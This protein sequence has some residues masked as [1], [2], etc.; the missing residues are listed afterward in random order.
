[1]KR[2]RSF[3][4]FFAFLC[5]AGAA[6]GQSCPVGYTATNGICVANSSG[7]GISGSIANGQLAI[8]SGTNAITGVTSSTACTTGFTGLFPAICAKVS[9]TGQ[10]AA[11]DTTNLQ[12]GGAACPAGAYLVS[13]YAL[14]TGGTNASPSVDVL[15]GWTDDIQSQNVDLGALSPYA[16]APFTAPVTAGSFI[17][18]P[19]LFIQQHSNA[20]QITYS[21]SITSGL[22]TSIYSLYITLERL[23]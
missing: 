2:L 22:G 11:I 6:W 23:Q 3:A 15:I 16:P 5:F 17:A 7:G 9:L 12:C 8:G 10:T 1:M 19:P 20:E 18:G 13:V 21:T 14:V 4:P